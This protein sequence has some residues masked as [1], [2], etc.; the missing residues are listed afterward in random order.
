MIDQV[1]YNNKSPW[2]VPENS[3]TGITLNRF[4][5]DNHFGENWKLVPVG[6]IVGVKAI[7]NDKSVN[8]YPNPASEQ[9]KIAISGESNTTGAIYSSTGELVKQ[10]KLEFNGEKTIDVSNLNNGI[11][12]IKIGTFTKKLLINK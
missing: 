9:I 7:S 11:Y 3:Q 1:I 6:E 10:F 4:D 2:P 5:V 8:V 12:L